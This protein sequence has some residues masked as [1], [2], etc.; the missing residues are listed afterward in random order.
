VVPIDA[1]YKLVGLIRLNW[2]GLSGGADVW[3]KIGEFFGELRAK[4]EVI[5]EETHA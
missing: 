2:R 4:A 1:C 3:Q 5:T